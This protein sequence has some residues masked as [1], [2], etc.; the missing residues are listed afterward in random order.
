MFARSSR[1]DHPFIGKQE[2]HEFTTVFEQTEHLTSLYKELTDDLVNGCI[3]IARHRLH[4]IMKVLTIATAIFLPLALL[5]GIY[6]MNFEDMPELKIAD[7]DC[8][9]L[10]VMR[11]IVAGLPECHS[12]RDE[13]HW[14]SFTLS[15]RT[16]V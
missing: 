12:I 2:C 15:A 3:A 4:Q 10:S 16:R 5:V 6:G 11:R 7:A 1:K 13:V 14:L 8:V 9:L